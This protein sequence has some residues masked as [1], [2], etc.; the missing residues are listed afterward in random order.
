MVAEE[1]PILDEDVRTSG[2]PSERDQSSLPGDPSI[3][4][5]RAKTTCS[6]QNSQRN[7]QGAYLQVERLLHVEYRNDDG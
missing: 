3:C 5:G 6:A 4:V 7:V 2:A 1:S